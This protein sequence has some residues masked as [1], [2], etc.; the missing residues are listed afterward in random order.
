VDEAERASH[1]VLMAGGRA[2]VAGTPA[3]IVAAI[4]GHLTAAAQ[5]PDG[6]ASWRRASRWRAWS[7]DGP[8]PGDEVP[9]DLEDA[10]IIAELTLEGGDDAAA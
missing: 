8:A 10:A 9:A 7:P 6:L 3:E 4:P 5:R 2:L 1:V